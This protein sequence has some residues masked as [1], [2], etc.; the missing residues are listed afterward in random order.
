MKI[1]LLAAA[2]IGCGV[3]MQK[4]YESNGGLTLNDMTQMVSDG[5]NSVSEATSSVDAAARKAGAVATATTDAAA[6]AYDTIGSIASDG[7]KAADGAASIVVGAFT[8][9]PS[10]S[11]QPAPARSADGVVAMPVKRSAMNIKPADLPP[12]Q[13]DSDTDR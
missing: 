2:A 11:A 1:I 5:T 6:H 10:S 7:M 8:S 13:R 12:I 4:V 3:L 9:K